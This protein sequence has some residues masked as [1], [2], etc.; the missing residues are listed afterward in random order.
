MAL[1]G[2]GQMEKVLVHLRLQVLQ[3]LKL[4]DV[5][6]RQRVLQEPSFDSVLEQPHVACRADLPF[7]VI[8]KSWC[9]RKARQVALFTGCARLGAGDACGMVRLTSAQS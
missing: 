3:G 9:K 8:N 6:T 4:G 5:V 2:A 7:L 1:N